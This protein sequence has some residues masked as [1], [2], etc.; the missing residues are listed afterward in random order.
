MTFDTTKAEQMLARH[1]DQIDGE[2]RERIETEMA[3]LREFAQQTTDNDVLAQRL[4]AFDHM[5]IPL[6]EAALSAGL[7]Q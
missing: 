3:A 4:T 5:T 7:K 6:A 2:L 1:G